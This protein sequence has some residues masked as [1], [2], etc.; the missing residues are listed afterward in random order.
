M[1]FVYWR[2]QKAIKRPHYGWIVLIGAFFIFACDSISERLM[3][4][5]IPS[6]EAEL[7]MSHGAIGGVVS[8]YFVTFAVMNIVWGILAD[9]VGP[10]KC[11]LI[12]QALMISGLFGMGFTDSFWNSFLFY[13]LCGAGAA[14]QVIGAVAIS[15]RWFVINK[16]GKANGILMSAVGVVVLTLGLV[17]PFILADLS[18]RWSWW[19]FAAVITIISI[20]CSCFLV[21]DP[22]GKGLEPIGAYK[23]AASGA[24]AENNNPK[25]KGPSV[26]DILRRSVTWNMA[27]IFFTWGIGY[28]IFATFGVTYLYEIGWPVKD[29]AEV[30][31][32]WGALSIPSPILWGILAD[33]MAKKHVLLILLSIQAMGMLIFLGGNQLTA[34]VG[35][36]AIGFTYLGVFVTMASA[37]GD[38]YEPKVIG[39]AFGIITACCG[40]GFAVGSVIRGHIADKSGTLHTAFLFGLAALASAFI[41]TLTLKKPPKY[42]V[43]G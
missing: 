37:I 32:I 38:Y 25:I 4:F 34:Y 27:S 31:A 29:A 16:R 13:V 41:L 12:G 2:L 18:W 17:I 30:F 8:G 3:P 35:A 5:L 26:K 42:S 43:T 1:R 6:M 33:R 40:V 21:D 24:P 9:R 7:S 28:V 15:S 22:A 36:A 23:D 39:T 10:R 14:A 20:L 11:I 19:I